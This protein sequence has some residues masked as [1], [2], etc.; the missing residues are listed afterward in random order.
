MSTAQE[1]TVRNIAGAPNGAAILAEAVLTE[2]Y[3]ER[4][5]HRFMKIRDAGS[6]RSIEEVLLPDRQSVNVYPNPTSGIVYFD[7][8]QLSGGSIEIYNL[9][10]Q[11]I[12]IQDFLGDEKRVAL[13]F[14]EHSAGVYFYRISSGSDFIETGKVIFTK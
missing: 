10:G 11:K 1:Q 14:K 7:I 5:D 6:K 9:N 8:S 2:A 13:S 3:N 4:F 12:F